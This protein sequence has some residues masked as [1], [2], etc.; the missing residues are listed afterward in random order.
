MAAFVPKVG[1]VIGSTVYIDNELKA[2][3]VSVTLPEITPTT[4]DVQALGTMTVP[5]WQ[6]LENMEMTFTKIG[7]D[8]GFRSCLKAG[9]T[10]LEVRFAQPIIG[11]QGDKKPAICKA[12]CRGM[13]GSIPGIGLEV[14]STI[15]SEI[16]FHLTRYQLFIEG[17]EA[18][19]VD[20]LA[21]IVRIGGETLTNDLSGL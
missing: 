9:M 14:G 6:L 16:T 10:A 3:D 21:G 17:Q 18:I 8:L 19:L 11:A 15:E 1:P 13:L 7:V 2:R 4:A 12:F 5:V 20:R